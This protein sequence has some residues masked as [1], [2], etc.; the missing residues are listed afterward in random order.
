MK[1]SN[2][3]VLAVPMLVTG[4]IALSGCGGRSAG[5][6]TTISYSEVGVCKSYDTPIGTTTAKTD[7]AFAVFKIEAVDNTKQNSAFNFDPQRMY[8]D[9]STAEQKSKSQSFQVRRFI[10]PDARFAQA[11]GVKG[12]QMTNIN[13]GEKLA[14]NGFVVVPLSTQN[15]ADSSYSFELV[16]DTSTTEQQWGLGGVVLTKTNPDGTKFAVVESCKELALK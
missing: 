2:I 5:N 7:E 8:V 14:A 6:P 4:S 16:Y 3:S 10:N 11:M 13:A 12:I 9:Q 1:T 15:P